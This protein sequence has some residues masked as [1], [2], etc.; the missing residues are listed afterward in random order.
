[1]E[2]VKAKFETRKTKQAQTKK[3]ITILNKQHK[4]EIQKLQDEILKIKKTWTDPEKYAKISKKNKD[5]EN[6][7]KSLKDDIARKKELMNSMKA[8]FEKSSI[9][10]STKISE[11]SSKDLEKISKLNKEIARKD[12]MIKEFRHMNEDLKAKEKKALD[13]TKTLNSKIKSLKNDLLRKEKLLKE[14][15]EKLE[16]KIKELSE[17]HEDKVDHSEI[18]EII[19]KHKQE[20][21]RK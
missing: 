10:A 13:D 3:E 17:E 5:L 19:K 9:E 11:H 1:M 2:S 6:S 14:T 4:A 16:L 18:K 21:E 12:T 7:V 15:K 20:L 8:N